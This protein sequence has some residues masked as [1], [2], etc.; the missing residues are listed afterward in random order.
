MGFSKTLDQQQ[1]L[2]L[3]GGQEKNVLLFGGSRSGK[4][5]ILLYSIVIRALKA[6]GS[7][8]GVFRACSSYVKQA[9]MMDTMPKMM[10]ICFPEVVFK[11]N[12]TNGVCRLSN[13]SE[14]WFCGLD[15]K[16][17]SEKI[18]GK[19]FATVYFNECS[20]ISYPAM[21]L[22]M[23]R[24]AQKAP[25]FGR[26]GFL[27]LKA[28]FDCNPPGKS[29]WSYK[30]FIQKVE[31][32][33]NIELPFPE[34]FASMLMNPEGNRDN[35][36]EGYIEFILGSL[37]ERKRQRFLEG[38]WL[39]DIEGALWQRAMINN[40][41]IINVPELE[42]IVIGVDPAITAN[43]SSN[44][45]GI[46]VAGKCRRGQYYILNDVSLKGSP[47][48]WASAVEREYKRWKADRVICEV[49][50]GGSL[51]TDNL[52]N[53]N[54]NISCKSVTASR[55]KIVRA[56]PIAALYEQGKVHHVGT[57]SKLEDQLCS[58]N[59]AMIQASPDRLDALV[60]ALSELSAGYGGCRAILA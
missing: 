37:P 17:N 11:Q 1:A 20:E 27:P 58:Y 13:G 48:E 43:A 15:D 46:I 44:E 59:P 31:P 30:M 36:G 8:H 53:V 14:V 5:F 47:L 26:E 32:E 28:Y 39:D 40:S 50:N 4:T 29:H 16:K 35:I 52:R 55:G 12:V 49:N 60:W 41:R 42:R 57:F 7:R 45:T 33:T 9:V 25:L 22:A 24:L 18:L 56:E 2:G 34:H 19:E 3:V 51:V 54:P 23:T 21:N 6:P 10:K 38:N